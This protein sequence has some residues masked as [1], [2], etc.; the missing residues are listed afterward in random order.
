VTLA[1]PV[2]ASPLLPFAVACGLGAGLGLCLAAA[3]LRRRPATQA[4]GGPL[5]AWRARR[6]R[7]PPAAL[8][9]RAAAAVA[10]AVAAGL[11]TRWPAGTV[12]AGLGA[13]SAP[14]VL[15]RDRDATAAIARAEAVAGWAEQLR[16][17]VTA[18]AGLEQAITATAPLAPAAIRGHVAVLAA[19][20]AGGDRLEDALRGL[21]DSVGDPA[22][23]LVA[24]ALIHAAGHQARR[25]GDL[26]GSLAASARAQAAM[27][28]RAEAGRASLRTSA[29]M[30]TVITGV[31]AAGL[32]ALSRGYL[33]PYDSPAGQAVL[34]FAGAIFA[35]G[36]ALLRR[37]AA[38]REPARILAPRAH[39]AR[40]ADSPVMAAAAGPAAGTE[41]A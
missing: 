32:V 41:D 38:I 20:I 36:F 3:G 40:A 15:G 28:Q 16:D 27:R 5:A 29:R 2:A 30:I 18:A 14:A 1:P 6:R 25:L 39:P 21:A 11:A 26:L 9:R 31:M 8:A 4:P 19:R 37:M 34:L 33:A 17:T 7:Q 35:A 13:W 12:L 22:G 24:A 23:D 10:A